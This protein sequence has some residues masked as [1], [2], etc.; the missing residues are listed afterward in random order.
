M[1]NFKDDS[2][3]KIV[4]THGNFR[5]GY[6]LRSRDGGFELVIN[7]EEEGLSKINWEQEYAQNRGDFEIKDFEAILTDIEKKII[8]LLAEERTTQEIGEIMKTSPVTVRAHIRTL[9]IKLQ[10]ATR[11]Q[12][13]AYSQGILKTLRPGE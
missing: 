10:C 2:Y 8:R 6:I 4:D 3:V 9:K 12:L 7:L 1:A 11:E 13:F 5:F